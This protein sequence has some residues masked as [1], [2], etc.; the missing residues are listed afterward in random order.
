MGLTFEDEIEEL[1]AAGFLLVCGM[2]LQDGVHGDVDG[3][4][5][6]ADGCCKVCEEEEIGHVGVGAGVEGDMTPFQGGEEVNLQVGYCGVCHPD[7]L[8]EELGQE[9][10][11]LLTFDDR[12]V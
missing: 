7:A 2:V 9:H 1:Y 5:L 10:G 3:G 4:I 12:Y 11:T 8:G 6:P